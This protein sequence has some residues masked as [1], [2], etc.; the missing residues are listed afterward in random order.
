RGAAA[1]TWNKGRGVLDDDWVS[2]QAIGRVGIHLRTRGRCLTKS[3]CGCEHCDGK[4]ESSHAKSSSMHDEAPL[5]RVTLADR[6]TRSTHGRCVRS[7]RHFRPPTRLGDALL[8]T[9]QRP[10]VDPR[11]YGHARVNPDTAKEP[12]TDY[13]A[14]S[15][16]YQPERRRGA[17]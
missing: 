3:R 5:V 13:R 12:P 8:E 9:G 2:C 4:G 17:R 1:S 6:A 14:S 7:N 15:R 10:G 11:W 16:P